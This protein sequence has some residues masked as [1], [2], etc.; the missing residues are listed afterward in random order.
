MIADQID[1]LAIPVIIEVASLYWQ[2]RQIRM[3]K[4]SRASLGVADAWIDN[5]IPARFPEV[6]SESLSGGMGMW[7]KFRGE[8]FPV[9]P[10]IRK[11]GIDVEQKFPELGCPARLFVRRTHQP[12]VMVDGFEQGNFETIARIENA[13]L[14][15]GKPAW[16]VP[17]GMGEG[18]HEERG[19]RA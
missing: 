8:P 6:L 11:R 7:I 2:G 5:P 1:V 15:S 13:V 16:P 4:R 17:A 9:E 12:L 18:R 14:P 19:S 10:K 3:E